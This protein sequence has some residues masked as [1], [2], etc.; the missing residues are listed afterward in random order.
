[1]YIRLFAEF[2]RNVVRGKRER[3]YNEELSQRRSVFSPLDL[4]SGI[5]LK[6]CVKS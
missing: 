3:K 4:E 2:A 5:A 1:M 6:D